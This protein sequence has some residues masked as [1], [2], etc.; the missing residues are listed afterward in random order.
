M[1]DNKEI[2]LTGEEALVYLYGG[3]PIERLDKLRHRRFCEKA[4]TSTSP[5]QVHIHPP[6]SAAAYYPS[7][8]VYYQV[9]EWMGQHG[10]LYPQ[11]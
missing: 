2:V 8:K 3:Q 1:I 11:E 6:T 4:F 9:Q 5:V 7:A 10:R